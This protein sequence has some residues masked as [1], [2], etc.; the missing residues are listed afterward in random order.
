MGRTRTARALTLLACGL[1]LAA[2]GYIVTPAEESSPTPQ[3]AAGTWTAIATA[4]K[5]TAAGDLHVDLALRND[6]GDWSAMTVASSGAVSLT[7]QDGKTSQ[8]G[9]AFVGTGGTSLAPGF[10]MR[11]Y[12]GGTKAKPETQL[13]Y[14][15][16]AGAASSPGS[17][18]AMSYTYVTGEFNYYSPAPPA[19][20][21]LEVDLDKP[22][23]DLAYPVAQSIEGLIQKPSEPIEAINKCKLTLTSAK[24]T[25]TGLE[26]SWHTENPTAYPTYVHIGTPP[27]IGSDGIIYGF[28][29][30]PHLADTP[31]TPGGEHADWSTT[32]DVPKDVTGLVILLSVEAKAQKNFV[33]HAVDITDK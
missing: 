26:F 7:T 1:V 9:T 31:I 13:L 30:S 5:Q 8:C 12:T 11:G 18:L 16:C 28:Y 4:V 32:V 6:T 17:K 24:R 29:E 33:S 27:V 22:T 3:T 20:G 15:E 23:A 10:E 21:K 14:V 19:S 25:A 2:C